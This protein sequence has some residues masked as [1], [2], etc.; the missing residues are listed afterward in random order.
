MVLV[1]KREKFKKIEVIIGKVFSKFPL[2]PN[3]YTLISIISA[4]FS[5]YFL[6][7]LKLLAALIF[8]VLAAFFDFVDGAI[9]RYSQKVTKIGAYL[10][11]I[12]DRYVEG[13]VLLGFLFLPLPKIGLP[14]QI[15][16]FL[17]LF[18]SLLITYSKAAAKEKELIRLEFEKGIFCRAE[19][20]ILISLSIILGIFNFSWMTWA[21]IFL[22]FL[23]NFSAIERIYLI[24]AQTKK[25]KI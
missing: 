5:F 11:T 14:A 20:I 2:S 24:L 23:S 4:F 25:E 12:S 1:Q 16:I 17:S 7:N 15:W 9:A 8:F 10:D 18:G 22:A 21:I 3:F 19:R 13:I 6:I